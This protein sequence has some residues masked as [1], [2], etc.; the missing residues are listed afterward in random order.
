MNLFFEG[1]LRAMPP[2]LLAENGRVTVIRPLLAVPESMLADYA[3]E[4]GFPIIDCGCWLCGAKDQER[5]RMKAIVSEIAGRYPAV[6]RS[7]LAALT[8]I[9]PRFM[10]DSRWHDF[11]GEEA[12]LGG[13]HPGAAE[14]AL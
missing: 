12:G 6:R 10:M 5:V 9:E 2:K 1:S 11:E 3:R 4:Q 8:R 7:I 14:G 13:T